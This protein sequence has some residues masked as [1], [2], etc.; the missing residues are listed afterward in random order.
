MVLLTMRRGEI[1]LYSEGLAEAL[2]Y[3][4]RAS[5]DKKAAENKLSDSDKRLSD[6]EHE[7]EF[8][9]RTYHEK[10]KIAKRISTIR[11][12]R[13]YAK[14]TIEQLTPVT[15]WLDKNQHVIRGLE[16]LLGDVVK[17]EQHTDPEKLFYN[18]RTDEIQEL[19][20]DN[21]VFIKGKADG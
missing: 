14:Y 21:K 19:F 9:S 8:G 16:R 20:D 13:R 1:L 15:D 12:E 3:F 2:E 11:K 6:L 7:L 5:S 4:K 10:A 17:A 18:Y